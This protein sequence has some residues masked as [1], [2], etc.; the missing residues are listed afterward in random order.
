[1]NQQPEKQIQSGLSEFW[2][3]TKNFFSKL[4]DLRK[5]V[6]PE[7][8]IIN[9]RNNKKMMGSNAWM[10]MCSIVIASIG[11][12][13]NSQ[14]VIIGA[15]LISPL[16][17]PILGVGMAVGINDRI[18]LQISLKHFGIAIGIALTT[19]LLYFWLTPFGG[20]TEQIEARTSPTFLD[21][22][23]AF[24]G[25]IAGIV[26]GSR[27]DLSNAIPGVAI[28]TA[29]M[30]P[31][32]VTGYGIANGDWIIAL[33]SFYLFFLNSVFVALATYM[34]VRW[35]KFPLHQ[36]SNMAEQRK[37]RNIIAIIAVLLIIPSFL[38]LRKVLG[39]VQ[40]RNNINTFVAENFQDA[41]PRITKINGTD[42]LAVRVFLFEATK[43]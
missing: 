22:L 16:M 13:Q 12:D 35:L 37:A 38:I 14:A 19:S 36:F 15:M 8:T 7:G 27:K 31:L 4:I 42:S 40:T 1:M 39:D 23:I 5:E 34:I 33:N 30:P 41:L 21:V 9:I 3:G 10:L 20:L 26:S 29:L 17:S 24:F 2:T 18:M 6:D 43:L 11:L 25:G 32:C 28:A